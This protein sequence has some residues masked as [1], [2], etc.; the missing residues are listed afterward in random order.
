MSAFEYLMIGCL[1]FSIGLFIVL[2]RKNVIL[3]L[4]GL[5]LIFNGANV[6][7]IGVS[8]KTDLAIQGQMFSMF[9]MVV[10]ACELAIALALIYKLYF[11][12]RENDPDVFQDLGES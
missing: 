2:T 12:F 4:M 10:A 1:L 9:V 3:I 11:H 6:N 7:L 5:E 8:A